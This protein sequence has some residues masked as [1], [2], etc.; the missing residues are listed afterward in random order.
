[1][2]VAPIHPLEV[3]AV[4]PSTGTEVAVATNI[5]RINELGSRPASAAAREGVFSAPI[6]EI[7][8]P[9]G[10]RSDV[11]RAPLRPEKSRASRRGFFPIRV[12]KEAF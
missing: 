10:A 5:L 12:V 8:H 11:R 7:G 2:L 3:Q 6:D 1:M 4:F 9:P